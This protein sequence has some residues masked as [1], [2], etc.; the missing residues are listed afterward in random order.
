[1]SAV[2]KRFGVIGA[3][4]VGLAVAAALSKAG[5]EVTLC[6]LRPELTECA[7]TSGIT[8]K[9][10]IELHGKAAAVIGSVD[11]FAK[12]PPDVL[13]VASKAT[14]VSL[15]ASSIHS[16]QR[17]G[18]YVVSWQNGIDTERALSEALGRESV[19]RAVVNFGVSLEK[20]CEVEVAFHHPPHFL[21]ETGGGDATAASAIAEI[22][23]R[24]GLPTARADNI[25]D[26]VWRKTI[27]N[28]AL[29]PVCAVTGMTMAEA[30][31][32][33]FIFEVV[34]R[35]LKECVAVAR[36]NEIS[37]G[38]DFYRYS[39]DYIRGAG[40]HKPSMVADIEAGR[41]TEVDFINGK[42]IEYAEDA[43][44]DAPLNRMIRALV[45]AAE[46]GTGMGGLAFKK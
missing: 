45:K 40:N 15:I 26:L 38:W 41:R 28:A 11:E 43:G 46:R 36:A 14:A 17:K 16:F 10:A 23:T 33:P 34:D 1:M 32:D 20:P 6:D 9:G 39:M 24:G 8:L 5:V 25:V 19:L 35:L 30:L 7:A 37:L 31:R 18:M 21:Q 44:L 12:A 27:L 3:G 29:S 13:F 22:L 42:I 4:P 2:F